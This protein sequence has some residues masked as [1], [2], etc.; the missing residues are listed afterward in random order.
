MIE[1]LS[2]SGSPVEGASTDI[3]LNALGRAVI[4]CLPAG[5]RA[6]NRF[7]KLNALNFIPC[8]ACGQAPE[9]GFCLYD[10]DL[11]GVYNQLF[12]CDCLLF[13]TP[14]YFDSV[15]AQ[16]KAF[17]D[18]CNCF[19]PADFKNVN[20]E[21]DFIQKMTRTRPGAM[22]LVGGKRGWFEGA[23]RT[24]AGYFKWLDITNEGMLV[25]KSDDFTRKG[26][27][28]NDMAILEEVRRLGSKL[29]GV[30]MRNR[31]V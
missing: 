14:V 2:V 4:D 7:I 17:I 26:A 22:V 18:R 21:H 28:S 9:N 27:A 16:A 12:V 3:L 30:V 20:P 13:G 11:T 10:D 23:R 24:V 19:R 31:R 15:S 25:Y 6:V 29:A 8:Q 1:I 5:T